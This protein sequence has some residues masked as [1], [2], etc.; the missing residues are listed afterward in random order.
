MLSQAALAAYHADVDFFG[1][2]ASHQ[3]HTSHFLV[4]LLWL[5]SVLLPAVLVF[6]LFA[7]LLWQTSLPL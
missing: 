7:S 2:V 4:F 6:V 5:V 1:A 3:I